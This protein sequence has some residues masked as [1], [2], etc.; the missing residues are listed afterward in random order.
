MPIL[1]LGRGNRSGSGGK[2]AEPTPSDRPPRPA[3]RES[4]DPQA[5]Q[6]QLGNYTLGAVD[7]LTGMTADEIEVVA[8]RL[9]DGARETEDVL[10]ELAH[11]VREYGL[12][13]NEGSPISS[14]RQT[15]APPGANHAGAAGPTQ[16]AAGRGIA[17]RDAGERPNRQPGR[18]MAPTIGTFRAEIE[19]VARERSAHPARRLIKLAAGDLQRSCALEYDVSNWLLA[20]R[21]PQL[22]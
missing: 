12:I 17:L 5:Q 8:D 1:G 7:Q 19:G 2:P 9:I 20:T 22:C 18:W 10:R 11:R 15:G 4:S 6:Y 14:R 16:R 3:A 21:R 13:A